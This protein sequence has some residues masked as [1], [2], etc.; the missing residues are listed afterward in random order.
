MSVASEDEVFWRAQATAAKHQELENVR[1]AATAWTALFTAVV[2]VFSTVAFA[3]GLPALD[4][5][6]P[7]WQDPVKYATVVA[8]ALALTATILAGIATGP[9]AKTTDDSSWK[10]TRNRA[11]DAARNARTQLRI[12]KFLGAVA[13]AVILGGS[14]AIFFAGATAPKAKLP[15]LIA[16]VGG[17]AV[18]GPLTKGSDGQAKV[19]Q[20]SLAGAT[21]ILVVSACP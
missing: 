13:A 4:D 3:G 6:D 9:S 15:S 18:C 7:T 20:E 14:V 10:G 19:G 12:S 21:S 1:K 2:G 5:L 16:V 11:R 17:K 8:L